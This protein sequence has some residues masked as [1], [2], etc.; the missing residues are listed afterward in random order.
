MTGGEGRE[1]KFL[2]SFSSGIRAFAA[3]RTR[4][5]FSFVVVLG[6]SRRDEWVVDLSVLP[7][8]IAVEF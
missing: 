4:L 1:G 5:I 2:I 3:R 7:V 8:A 6:V